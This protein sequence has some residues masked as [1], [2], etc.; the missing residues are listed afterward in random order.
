MAANRGTGTLVGLM[1]RIVAAGSDR[2]QQA[3]RKY[4]SSIAGRQ[5]TE[6]LSFGYHQ[7]SLAHM[8]SGAPILGP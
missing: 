4:S 8:S 1:N 6:T 2:S 5:V 7:P 3:I